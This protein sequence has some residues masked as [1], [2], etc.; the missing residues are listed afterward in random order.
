MW[1]EEKKMWKVTVK[2]ERKI[3]GKV[4]VAKGYFSGHQRQLTWSK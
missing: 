2:K 3:G 4:K 1:S